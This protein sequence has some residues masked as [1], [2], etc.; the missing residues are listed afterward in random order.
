M[1]HRFH[2]EA[3]DRTLQDICN[4]KRPFGGKIVICSGDWR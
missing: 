4:D 3:M 2:A 1:M